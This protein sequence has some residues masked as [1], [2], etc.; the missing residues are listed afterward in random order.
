[1]QHQA[2]DGT[3]RDADDPQ[4][5]DICHHQELGV[6]ASTHDTLGKDAVHALE[7]NDQADGQHQ[8]LGNGFRFGGDVVKADDQRADEHDKS[9]GQ[10]T[11]GGAQHQE[12]IALGLGPLHIT[13]AQG[14]ANDHTAG[15]A[16]AG[17]KDGGQLLGDGGNGIGRDKAASDVT[18]NDGH[19]TVA[20]AQQSITHQHRDADAQV[21]PQHI[22]ALTQQVADTVADLLIHEEDIAVDHDKLKGTSNQRTQR[23]TGHAHFG[24]AELTENEDIVGADI[25]EKRDDAGKQRQPRLPHTAQDNGHGQGH[26][27]QPIRYHRPV[28][29][30]GTGLNDLRFGRVDAHNE[31]RRNSSDQRKSG[32]QRNADAE[33]DGDGLLQAHQILHTPKAGG[34]HRSTHTQS[35]TADMEDIDELIGQG[36]SAERYL[37]Q[38][39]HHDGVHNVDTNGDE[40]LGRDGQGNARRLSIKFS[41]CN[42][43]HSKAL[44]LIG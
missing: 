36:G 40:A 15:L 10:H 37:T 33:H 20:Q 22:A 23:S 13:L 5:E 8:F 12:G 28:E 41:V 38:V 18:H 31:A 4:K 42:D 16:D 3:H 21:L 39:T 19:S 44:L 32:G 14:V 27:Q 9:A 43:I 26:T 1:M 34:Q 11:N 7:D 25:D 35:H 17:N 6:A 24:G 2:G 30:L 29:V